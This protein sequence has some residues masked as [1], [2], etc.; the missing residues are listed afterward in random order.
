MEHLDILVKG[1]VQRVWYRQSTL[2]KALELGVFGCVKNLPD[3][4]VF[5]EVEGESEILKEFVDWCRVGPVNA[6]VEKV[7]SEKKRLKGFKIF[8]IVK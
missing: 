1:K 6:K 3:G 7:I 2:E 4:N 8:Q 5:I